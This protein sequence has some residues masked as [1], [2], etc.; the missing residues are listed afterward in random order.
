MNHKTVCILL[1]DGFEETETIMPA[2]ILKRLNINVILAGIETYK[3]RGAHEFHLFTE[4]LLSDVSVA[5][6]DALILPGGLPGA[7]NLRNSE[8]VTELIKLAYKSHKICA[9]ICAAP[10]VLHDAGITEGHRITGYPGTEQ[11]S[12]HNDFH[13]TGADVEHDGQIITAKGMGKADMFAFEIARALG[14]E[15]KQIEDV[16]KNAFIRLN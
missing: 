7:L 11:L 12:K 15:E 9:A 4:T 16:A 14:I 10:V 1:A 13:Y 2:D 8:P 6:F 5:D 3:V